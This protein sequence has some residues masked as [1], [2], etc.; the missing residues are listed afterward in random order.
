VPRSRLQRSG[1]SAIAWDDNQAREALVSALVGDATSIVQALSETKLD[2]RAAQ[3]LELLALVVGQDVEPV[4]GSDGTD[5]RWR[6]ARRVAGDRV[7]STV[8]PQARHV[9]KTVHHRQDRTA[10]SGTWPSSPTPDCLPRAGILP[11]LTTQAAPQASPRQ[12]LAQLSNPGASPH[13]L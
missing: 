7:I 9:H 11:G 2:E 13:A 5:G 6:I 3:T 8:D 10:T 4:E 1:K 12:H